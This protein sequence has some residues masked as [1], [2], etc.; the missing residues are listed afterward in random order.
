MLNLAACLLLS[1]SLYLSWPLLASPCLSLP[2]HAS[3]CP[4]RQMP[5]FLFANFHACHLPRNIDSFMPSAFCL[6]PSAPRKRIRELEKTKVDKGDPDFF[7]M[8]QRYERAV[9]KRRKEERALEQ[10]GGDNWVSMGDQERSWDKVK[11]PDDH[12]G[13]D[14]A[15]KELEGL[16]VAPGDGDGAGGGGFG[17]GGGGCF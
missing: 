3:P 14:A 4:P 9:I 2:R 17:S 8:K 1:A 12:S 6:V 5:P 11:G 7:E 13:L 16:S 10:A 15:L